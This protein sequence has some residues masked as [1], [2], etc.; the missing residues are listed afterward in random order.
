MEFLIALVIVFIGIGAWIYWH[1]DDAPP[2]DEDY[3]SRSSRYNYEDDGDN[4]DDD[5][6]NDS[7]DDNDD[8][9]SDSDSD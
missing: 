5:S 3:F 1:G 8:G 4:N 6:D 9:D 7:D 2:D